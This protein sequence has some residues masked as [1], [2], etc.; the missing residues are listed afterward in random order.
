MIFLPSQ[1]EIFDLLESGKKEVFYV[2]G[3]GTGKTLSGAEWMYDGACDAGFVGLIGAPTHELLA[4]STLIEMLECWTNKGLRMGADGH[5]VV[6]VLPPPEWGVKP[7]MANVKTDKIITFR[8]GS[9]IRLVS[10]HDPNAAEGAKY[11]RIWVDEYGMMNIPKVRS[12][13][14]DRLRGKLY[15]DL[16]RVHQI[17]YTGTPPDSSAQLM[18]LRKIKEELI[19][20]DPQISMVHGHT[21]D[22]PYL[23]PDYIDYNKD[24]VNF[25]RDYEGSLEMPPTNMWLYNWVNDKHIREREFTGGVYYIW[26]DFNRTPG[27]A[28]IVQHNKAEHW[29]HVHDEIYLEGGDLPMVC[30]M[31][32]SRYPDTWRYVVG[33][34]GSGHAGTHLDRDKTSYRV[35]LQKYGISEKQLHLRKKNPLLRDSS[36]LSNSI[37]YADPKVLSVTV[38]S[39]CKELIKDIQLCGRKPDDTVLAPDAMRGHLLDCLRYYLWDNWGDFIRIK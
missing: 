14:R 28:I 21:A 4:T 11:D 38:S 31:V 5:Y 9:Y 19:P 35:M 18:E 1:N 37:M 22:N 20:K 3:K 16:K 39:K 23:P 6:G 36:L 33:G 24:P 34:D 12:K 13:L 29:L 8:W 2:G 10:L 15:K 27:T 26:H 7:L 25:R 30:E 17:L 32:K